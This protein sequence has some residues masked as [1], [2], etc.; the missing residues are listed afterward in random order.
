LDS[1]GF[2]IF[3][4]SGIAPCV[5]NCH[6]DSTVPVPEFFLPPQVTTLVRIVATI[7]G[8]ILGILYLIGAKLSAQASRG[9]GFGASFFGDERVSSD[10]SARSIM[11]KHHDR[12][13]ERSKALGFEAPINTSDLKDGARFPPV[14]FNSDL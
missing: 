13:I 5:K 7:S 1:D 4:V 3:L 6:A 2:T 10:Q 11:H 14:F 8:A 9:F 12:G